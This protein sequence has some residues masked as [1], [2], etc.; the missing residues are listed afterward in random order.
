MLAEPPH[1]EDD[2]SLSERQREGAQA[3]L[4]PG[5]TEDDGI[6][7]LPRVPSPAAL[8]ERWHLIRASRLG[9]FA[10]TKAPYGSMNWGPRGLPDWPKDAGGMRK[11]SEQSKDPLP[12]RG[13]RGPKASASKLRSA[14]WICRCVSVRGSSPE[15]SPAGMPALRRC[16]SSPRTR[17]PT[18]ERPSAGDS[19]RAHREGWDNYVRASTERPSGGTPEAEERMAI[20][21]RLSACIGGR[22]SP[23]KR[24]PL[25]ARPSADRF[26]SRRPER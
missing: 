16:E 14:R 13:S 6:A 11:G 9:A 23:G 17:E 3:F 22:V 25:A 7:R 18:E 1:H 4:A 26:G 20:P 2:R 12:P 21:D 24:G 19:V 5:Q 15:T 8:A 10:H